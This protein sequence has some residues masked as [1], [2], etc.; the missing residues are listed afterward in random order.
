MKPGTPS[1]G[2]DSAV[3]I[4]RMRGLVLRGTALEPIPFRQFP[5]PIWKREPTPEQGHEQPSARRPA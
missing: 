2:H 5:P 1:E 4:M 3:R